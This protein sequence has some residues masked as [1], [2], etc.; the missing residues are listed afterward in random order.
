MRYQTSTPS[1]NDSR[2]GARVSGDYICTRTVR[3]VRGFVLYRPPGNN[4][5]L[6]LPY[7]TPQAAQG[8]N[9]LT[10]SASPH[11]PSRLKVGFPILVFRRLCT[12]TDVDGRSESHSNSSGRRTVVRSLHFLISH[13]YLGL[14]TFSRFTTKVVPSISNRDCRFN[15]HK[16]T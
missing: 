5:S 10:A 4:P 9:F 13:K 15:P 1:Q 16:I 14:T 2:P 7:L 8:I 12:Q 6:L 11:T 3:R